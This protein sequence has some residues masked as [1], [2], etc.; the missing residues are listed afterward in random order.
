MEKRKIKNTN[1]HKD[2][3]GNIKQIEVMFAHLIKR[4]WQLR[5]FSFHGRRIRESRNAL[6]SKSRLRQM[7]HLIMSLIKIKDLLL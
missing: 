4:G 5:A 2:I 6:P 1:R 3:K 7:V